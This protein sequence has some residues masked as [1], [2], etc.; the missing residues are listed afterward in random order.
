MSAILQ[1]PALR[2]AQFGVQTIKAA[3][4]LPQTATAT[5][6]TVAGGS[7][8]ITSMVG[9]V[10]TVIGST[11]TTLALGTV[12]TTGTAASTG[13]A[14]ATA[15]TSKEA[16]TWMVPL[17]NAGVAGALVV[18]TN[19]GNPIFLPTPFIVPAGTISWTTSASTTGQIKWY[20]TWVALDNGASLS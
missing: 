7:V 8:L 19:G 18:G 20:F 17:V 2:T 5:L 9:L 10:T 6:A 15:I 1:G 11:A 3:Q 14:T 12:P 16:G 4:N 13:I